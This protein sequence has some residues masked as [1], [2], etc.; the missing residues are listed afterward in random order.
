MPFYIADYLADT[1]RLS[2]AEHGAYMLLIMEYWRNG[3]LPDDD[4]KLARIIGATTKEWVEIRDAIAD[5]FDEGWKHKRI[6]LELGKH[7]VIS[8]RRS[9]AASKR[10]T[11]KADANA[12]QMHN[13]SDANAYANGMRS[14][15]Q[16][17]ISSNEDINN[18]S[19]SK[20]PDGCAVVSPSKRFDDQ[21]LRTTAEAWNELANSLGLATV[22]KLT[23]ARKVAITRRAKEL[24]EDFDFENPAAGFS[25]LFSKIRG[26]P[27][28]RG[29]ESSW[30]CDFDW[31]FA[32]SNFTKIMEGKYENRPQ[33]VVS[34]RR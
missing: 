12:M 5:F 11:S 28:L 30:R 15:P 25:E 27:F 24:V 8:E 20:A 1:R 22:A 14:Q 18:T 19:T 2:L 29:N 33:K 6:D 21:L 26:S 7:C 3:G 9:A 17:H 16:P 13:E 34:F 32:L 23:D 4:K 10:W 31:C